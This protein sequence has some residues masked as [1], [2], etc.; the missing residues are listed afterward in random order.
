M[1]RT[2]GGFGR[3]AGVGMGAR[4]QVIL[5]PLALS[6]IPPGAP[7]RRSVPASVSTPVVKSSGV[8]TLGYAVPPSV[9]CRM[10]VETVGAF[11]RTGSGFT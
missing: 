4:R 6:P 7:T 10:P 11:M 8:P 5:K 1:P 2:R 9:C 3:F